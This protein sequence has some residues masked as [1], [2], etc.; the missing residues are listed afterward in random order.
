MTLGQA[1]C[2]DDGALATN[3]V[4]IPAPR[5][6]ALT[7]QPCRAV[8]KKDFRRRRARPRFPG[9]LSFPAALAGGEGDADGVGPGSRLPPYIQVFVD[10]TAPG[11][12]AI[13]GT[14]TWCPWVSVSRT[15]NGP[16]PEPDGAIQ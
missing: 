6:R 9:T 16:G 2:G 4:P 13:P 10:C 15:V 1:G 7:L 8:V 12:S 11:L 5:H 3:R 14:V